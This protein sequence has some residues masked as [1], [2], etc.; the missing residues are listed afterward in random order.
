ME[1]LRLLRFL[2]NAVDIRVVGTAL[3]CLDGLRRDLDGEAVVAVDRLVGTAL[4]YKAG[5]RLCGD[6]VRDVVYQRLRNCPDL[7]GGIATSTQATASGPRK[8]HPIRRN[9]PD[10]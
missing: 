10:L 8:T 2:P 3:I 4:I 9:C 5:L 7:Y 1:G 6:R